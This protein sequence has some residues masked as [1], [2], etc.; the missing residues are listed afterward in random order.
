MYIVQENF[1]DADYEAIRQDDVREL[2][3]Q[4]EVFEVHFRRAGN[5]WFWTSVNLHNEAMRTAGISQ[6]ASLQMQG[7]LNNMAY[8]LTVVSSA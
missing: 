6:Q 1:S 2:L 5:V 7:L 4:H 8:T 3:L